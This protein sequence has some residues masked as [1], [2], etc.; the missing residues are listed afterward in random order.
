VEFVGQLEVLMLKREKVGKGIEK[1]AINVYVACMQ[2]KA[3][4]MKPS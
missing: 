3:I 1:W 4:E 2:G